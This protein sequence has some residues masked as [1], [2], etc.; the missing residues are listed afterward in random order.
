MGGV[1]GVERDESIKAFIDAIGLG[2]KAFCAYYAGD[3]YM[4]QGRYVEAHALYGKAYNLS[5]QA[6]DLH[7][8]R[9]SNFTDITTQQNSS[10]NLNKLNAL[11]NKLNGRLALVKAKAF[12]LKSGGGNDIGSNDNIKYSK[13]LIERQGEFNGGTIEN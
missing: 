3:V 4:K 13:T 1:P 11:L 8:E 10:S 2:C 6:V 12:L 9:A 5:E 7:K